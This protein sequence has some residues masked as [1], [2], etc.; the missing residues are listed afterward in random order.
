LIHQ[1]VLWGLLDG[2]LDTLSGEHFTEILPLLR[3][4]FSTF[5]PPERQ[6]MGQMVRRGG[7]GSDPGRPE[8]PDESIDETRAKR[9][10]PTLAALLGD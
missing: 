5:A 10:L 8:A 7:G 4:T 3:R 2:W 6:Q 1:P 9:L